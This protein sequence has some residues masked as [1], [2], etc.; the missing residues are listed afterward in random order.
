MLPMSDVK[1]GIIG[2]SGLY[3]LEG[4]TDTR[5]EA[6]STPFGDPS[7]AYLIGRFD[8]RTVVF[9]PRH[10]RAHRLLPSE[11]PY[12]ANIYGLKLLGCEWV[13]AVS[14]VGSRR[15]TRPP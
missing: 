3:E 15:E 13:G 14:A 12:R 1:I 6:V 7:D 9:L 2:G 4:L 10:G 11:V 5:W 8:G